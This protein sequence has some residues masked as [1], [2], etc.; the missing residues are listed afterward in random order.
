MPVEQIRMF[1]VFMFVNII[2]LAYFFRMLLRMGL[3]QS[4]KAAPEGSLEASTQP[5]TV[6]EAQQAAE[7]CPIC[8]EDFGEE[9]G[10]AAGIQQELHPGV[11]QAVNQPQGFFNHNFTAGFG[12]AACSCSCGF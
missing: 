9:D 1:E 10:L 6:Q 5:V 7:Q 2:G 11:G 3:V 12:V 4:A 8:L